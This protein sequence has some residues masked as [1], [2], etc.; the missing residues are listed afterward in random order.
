M[1][2]GRIRDIYGNLSTRLDAGT[3]A[4][5]LYERGALNKKEF[6]EIQRLSSSDRPTRA[7]E[8][9][10]NIVLSQTD[11][12]Y[13]CFLDSLIKTD[14]LDVHQSIVLEGLLCCV[15]LFNT[16]LYRVAQKKLAQFLYA[17][18]LSNSKRFSKLFHCQ[19]Q[20]KICNNTVC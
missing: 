10:L 5:H 14:Q 16:M 19:Y 2:Q 15:N 6:E 11:D 12:F 7:A 1:F 13:D 9:L 8:E 3:T 20:K 4:N 17:L 18:T